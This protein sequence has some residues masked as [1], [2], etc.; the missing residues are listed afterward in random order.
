MAQE[1]KDKSLPP[2]AHDHGD[3]VFWGLRA[4]D[5][6]NPYTVV[7]ENV[8]DFLKSGAGYILQAVLRRMGYFVDARVINPVDY[9]ELTARKRAIIVGRT[10]SPVVWP[11]PHPATRTLGAIL[12]DNNEWFDR[13]TK[14]WLYEH[15]DKQA[16]KGNGFPSQQ[17]MADSLQVGTIKKR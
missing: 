13:T 3:M 1:K 16:A 5:A 6:T 14:M 17:V 11:T 2:E 4:I 12:E 9:G 15:W 10:G 8:P 7:I